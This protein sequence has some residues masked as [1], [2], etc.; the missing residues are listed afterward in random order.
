MVL[1]KLISKLST[2]EAKVALS[3]FLKPSRF[4]NQIS[5]R[6]TEGTAPEPL[7]R[8]DERLPDGRLVGRVTELRS[9]VGAGGKEAAPLP[10]REVEERQASGL[11][12]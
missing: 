12:M 11:C 5:V 4:N 10:Y 1:W 8:A 3:A 2:I 6:L 7:L 9:S